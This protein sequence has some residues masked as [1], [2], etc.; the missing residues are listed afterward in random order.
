[1]KIKDL[2]YRI[3]M[4]DNYTDPLWFKHLSFTQ[5]LTLYIKAEDIWNYRSNMNIESKKKIVNNGI[6]FNIP[7]HLLKTIK[8]YMKLQNI[9]LD[10]FMR[11]I[12][13]GV[14]RDERKLGAILLLTALVEVSGDAANALPHLVQV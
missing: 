11:L 9:I 5:L 13:E 1:M 2:F 8:N 12:T 7:H 14:D 10:E 6:A 3:N 4:L